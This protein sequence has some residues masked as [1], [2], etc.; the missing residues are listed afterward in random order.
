MKLFDKIY[1]AGFFD[2]EGCVLIVDNKSG[3]S[4][5]CR[6]GAYFQLHVS[7]RNTDEAILRWIKGL[8]GGSIHECKSEN[9]LHKDSWLWATASRIAESFLR[10]ILPYLRVKKEQTLLGLEF[11]R[12]ISYKTHRGHSL[13]QSE[14]ERRIR[15]REKIRELNA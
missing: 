1:V 7:I 14:L 15:L 5:S 4:H 12:G 11:Q 9:P 3:K 8:F 2:G 13:P 6:E 10:T